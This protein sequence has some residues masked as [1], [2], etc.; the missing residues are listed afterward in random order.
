MG[1]EMKGRWEMKAVNFSGTNFI[2]LILAKQ[3]V[4]PLDLNK[5]SGNL[6]KDFRK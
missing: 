6:N 1:G 4:R 2:H 3:R 5:D